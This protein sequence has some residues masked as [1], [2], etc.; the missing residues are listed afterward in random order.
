[1]VYVLSILL[2]VVGFVIGYRVG[3]YEKEILNGKYI[4]VEK[5]SGLGGDC[6][7]IQYISLYYDGDKIYEE[8]D[9]SLVDDTHF[10]VPV[11]G[12]ELYINRTVFREV[13]LDG[14]VSYDHNGYNPLTNRNMK[15]AFRNASKYCNRVNC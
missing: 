10:F 13:H 5:S 7:N 2:S 14:S 12:N 6:K 4:L 3:N 15:K 8:L 1:M 11:K 9:H